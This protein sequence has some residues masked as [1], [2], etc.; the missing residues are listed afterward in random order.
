MI[1]RDNQITTSGGT[2]QDNKLDFAL[3]PQSLAEYVG[4]EDV[5]KNLTDAGIATQIHYPKSLPELAPYQSKWRSDD[6]PIAKLLGQKGLSLPLYPELSKEQIEY[7]AET[8]KKI[9]S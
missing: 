9:L 4:Q 5:K 8:L 3:R 1:E 2:M 7:V 6:F